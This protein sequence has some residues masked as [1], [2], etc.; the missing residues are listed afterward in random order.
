LGN[1]EGLEISNA[2]STEVLFR[3]L[4]ADMLEGYLDDHA[5]KLEGDVDDP[6]MRR[7]A[8]WEKISASVE[9]PAGKAILALTTDT[10]PKG[11]ENRTLDFAY[12]S[13]ATA[14]LFGF[15]WNGRT[16][17]DTDS[18]A[19]NS[20]PAPELY[21][22]RLGT[23]LTNHIVDGHM[24]IH[25]R[26]FERG[27]VA[28]NPDGKEATFTVGSKFWSAPLTVSPIAVGPL[29][30]GPIT[31]GPPPGPPS[32]LVDLYSTH[33][34]L[35]STPGTPG[36]PGAAVSAGVITEATAALT[37]PPLSGR[38]YLFAGEMTY[39]LA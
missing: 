13:F 2:F 23:A 37:L 9:V 16:L 12:L 19:S 11:W 18:A 36:T 15:V 7:W 20:A 10:L 38:V 39:R 35:D 3:W 24:R 22:V 30:V 6:V 31:V 14:R 26:M 21:R 8:S 17:L 34:K 28:V 32:H 33:R 27:I 4:D 25:Y 5:D 1:S 29:T